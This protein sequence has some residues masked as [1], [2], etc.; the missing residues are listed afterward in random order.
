[1][2]YFPLLGSDTGS[3]AFDFTGFAQDQFVFR[4]RNSSATDLVRL[5]STAV[6]RD[7]SS[8]YH[9]VAAYDSANATSTERVKL[10]VNGVQLTAFDTATY[11]SLNQGLTGTFLTDMQIGRTNTNSTTQNYGDGYI[12]EVNFIDGQALTPSSFGQYDPVTGAWEPIS[13][14][15]T[16]GTNGF[17]LKFA[18]NSSA[19]ALGTDSS[20]NGN[21]WTVNN[22]SVTAGATY[23]SM[24]DVPTLTSTT[25]ANYA[26]LNP[27]HTQGATAVLSNGNLQS[28]TGST[29][30]KTKPSTIAVSS[31]KWYWEVTP[32][33]ASGGADYVV[34]IAISTF[35]ATAVL[36]NSAGE[37]GY[38]QNG[39]KISNGTITAYGSTYTTND[40]IGVA[41]DLNAG[42]IVFYKNNVSQ[43]TA[44]SGITGTYVA[45]ASD[46]STAQTSTFVFNFGQRG[47]NYTPPSGFVA[48]NTYNLPTPTI[49]NGAAQ[50]A[51][52]L[53][54]GTNATL[55]IT[56]TVNGKAMQP[57]MLWV[58]SRSAVGN[59][60]VWDSVRGV[61][62]ALNTSS[63]AAE[64][65]PT[66][67]TGL[68]SF[69]SNGFTLGNEFSG[70]G[71]SNASGVT[72]VA[73]Q[74]YTNGGS[75]SSN[76]SGT[77]TSNVSANPTAGF[78]IVTYAGTG[79][80]ATVGHGLGVA[81][82]MII[83]KNRTD[84]TRDWQVYHVSLTSA[85]Y[86]VQFITAAQ[87]S[88]PTQFN[89]TAP[90][91][92]VFSV[93]TASATNGSTNTFVAYC[94][95]PV[96]GYSAFG[97]YTGNGS[98]DGP[99]V[100]LGFRPRFLLIKRTDAVANWRIHDSSRDTYDVTSKSL[101]PNLSNAE[102]SA[103]SEYWDFLSNGFKLR[104]SD[105]ESNASSGTY[106]YMAFAENPFRYALAY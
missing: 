70:T 48:L 82:S 80:N 47:F 49:P 16:Y 39:N 101:Y 51:A 23:D 106:I 71:S 58:K 79:A 64:Q 77:I 40:I 44:Y 22:V 95:A 92:S 55:A 20:G 88:N 8:W 17:Y 60:L 24:L 91:S 69:N 6:Y 2:T 34:G 33:A 30:T 66:A 103:A 19:A 85:A 36:G 56:N 54:T 94:F 74:W 29:G 83:V 81:P 13:Y 25:A 5:E 18:D 61:T 3:A 38:V 9:L 86:T 11:P 15:G 41:L 27:L 37:Y 1:L 62:K 73:W 75:V 10:Y 21:T 12:A 53:Y 72:Y 89:S 35:T 96:A 98:T 90:T 105:A 28:T 63:S 50:M 76:T 14:V 45:L 52:T 4:I 102:T 104:T 78:S 46:G 97:G 59:H 42:T 99:F 26:T 87:A 67:G 93:G 57:D 65:T 84:G 100:Y 7:F 68:T 43:G 31:G 32:T